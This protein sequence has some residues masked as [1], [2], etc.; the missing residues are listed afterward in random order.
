M[1]KLKKNENINNYFKSY[2]LTRIIFFTL[3]LILQAIR[4]CFSFIIINNFIL[5]DINYNLKINC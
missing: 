3:P 4:G 2:N 5:N 1:R